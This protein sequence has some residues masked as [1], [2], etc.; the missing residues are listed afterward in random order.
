[1][2]RLLITVVV[3]VGAFVGLAF[4]AQPAQAGPQGYMTCKLL[5]TDD[6]YDPIA[7]RGRVVECYF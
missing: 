2:R 5:I 1:M 7:E 3:A 4:T 6:D